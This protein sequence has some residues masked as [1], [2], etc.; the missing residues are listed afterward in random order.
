LTTNVKN[1]NAERYSSEVFDMWAKKEVLYFSESYLLKKY[2]T[3]SNKS[4]LEKEE[5]EEEEFLFMLRKWVLAISKH[6][7]LSLK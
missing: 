4:V 6:L 3:D 1:L 5:Q 2:L 7:I